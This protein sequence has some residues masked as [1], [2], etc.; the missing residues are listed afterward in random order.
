MSH[1]VS[2]QG[3]RDRYAHTGCNPTPSRSTIPEYDEFTVADRTS[4]VHRQIMQNAVVSCLR[5]FHN[6]LSL[7][8]ITR[9]FC[10]ECG[11]ADAL[12]RLHNR[13]ITPQV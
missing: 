7:I 8:I 10:V 2:F 3:F 6:S 12:H 13:A 1:H 5:V 11:K 4:W 9:S